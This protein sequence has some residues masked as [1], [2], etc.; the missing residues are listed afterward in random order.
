M[1]KLHAHADDYKIRQEPFYHQIA[2]EMDV[3]EAADENRL[4]VLI[5]GL[6]GCGKTRFVEYMAWRLSRPLVNISCHDDLT[7]SDMVGRYLVR[8]GETVWI[9]GSLT[10][11]C[12]KNGRNLLSG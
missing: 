4:P 11:Q 5:K 8:G 12:C 3:F 9:D 10:N 6:T 1:E 7:T 2:N